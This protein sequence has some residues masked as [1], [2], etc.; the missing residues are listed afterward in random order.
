VFEEN[1]G[2]WVFPPLLL[3][4]GNGNVYAKDLG[5][6]DSMLLNAYPDRPVYLLRPSSTDLGITP[7][8]WPA[9]RD[10][11]LQA[12]RQRETP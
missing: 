9:N 7:T 3:A 2:F 8:F 5:Q 12:G 10:S 4:G 11:I 1:E 6:R